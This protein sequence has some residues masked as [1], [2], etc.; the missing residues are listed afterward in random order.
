MSSDLHKI[1]L[2]M[3]LRRGGITDTKILSAMEVIPRDRFVPAAMRDRAYENTALPIDFDQT[4]SQPIVV[5]R[6]AMALE[7][8][9]RKKVLEVGTGSGYNAAVLS[10]L[11]RRVYTIERYR[12]MVTQAEAIFAELGLHNITAILG[13]GMQGWLPQAPFDRIS[14]TAAADEPPPALVDQLAE[15]GIMVMPV[16]GEHRVQTL[17]R[18][19]KTESRIVAEPLEEVRFVPLIAGIAEDANGSARARNG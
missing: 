16:G 7:L 13:D 3:D 17:M 1:R 11:A 10:R 2:I 19:R 15:G 5:A 9:E 14:V 12:K 8:T 6:M 18:Y 4:I